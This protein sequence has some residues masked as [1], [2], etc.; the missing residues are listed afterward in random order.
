MGVSTDPFA[1]PGASVVPERPVRLP[2]GAVGLAGVSDIRRVDEAWIALLWVREG[3]RLVSFRAA[4]SPAGP[5]PEPPA[6][7]LLPSLAGALSGWILEADGRQ[8]LGLRAAAPP[9]AARAW[10]GPLSLL[11]WIGWEPARAAGVGPDE[12]AQV[13]LEGFVRSVEG[14]A[15]P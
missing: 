4:A 11:A 12:L 9:D 5:P 2:G 8:Q 6:V 3:E 1:V 14:L 13:A 15:R 7:R 10:D